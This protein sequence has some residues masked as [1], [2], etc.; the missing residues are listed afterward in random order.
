M[1]RQR[2]A[3]TTELTDEAWQIFKPLL[4]PDKTGGRPRTHPLR[5]VRNGLQSVLRAG[6]A[7]RLMPPELPPGQTASPPGRAWRQDGT[8]LRLPAQRRDRVR[9]QMGRPPQPAAA[10]IAAPSVQ[11]TATGGRTAT[12]GPRG[13]AGAHASA[14][15]RPRVSSG[16]SWF[17]PP[18]CVRRSRRPGWWP[19]RVPRTPS[20][21]ACGPTW[22]SGVPRGAGGGPRTGVGARRW[23][24]GPDAGG[25]I[26]PRSPHRR[27]RR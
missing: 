9:T 18:L 19:R 16:V 5:E 26:P 27:G 11:T 2:L 15:W 6:G 20:G 14:W 10:V 24:R 22:P 21:N 23:S 3:S 7:W 12:M 4:P 8:W 17:T 1:A 25:G 13:A